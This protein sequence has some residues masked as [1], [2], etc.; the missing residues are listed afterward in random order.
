VWIDKRKEFRYEETMACTDGGVVAV[1]AGITMLFGWQDVI[2]S[3]LMKVNLPLLSIFCVTIA[4]SL[5]WILIALG[6]YL[7]R[8]LKVV[9]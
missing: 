7:A 8:W 6:V 1:F 4:F 9:F 3:G 5:A 2:V